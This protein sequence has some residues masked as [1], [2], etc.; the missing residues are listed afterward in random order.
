MIT[1][2]TDDLSSVAILGTMPEASRLRRKAA[3]HKMY[4]QRSKRKWNS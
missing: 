4:V 2:V 1:T 3:G